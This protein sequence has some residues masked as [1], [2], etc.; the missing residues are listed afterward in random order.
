MLAE[1]LARNLIYPVDIV[2]CVSISGS[3]RES[4]K[5]LVKC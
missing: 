5:G 1:N 4:E 3:A 2:F